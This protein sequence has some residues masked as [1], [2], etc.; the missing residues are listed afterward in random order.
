M[1]LLDMTKLRGIAANAA[2]TT[3][4]LRGA[5]ERQQGGTCRFGD[6]LFISRP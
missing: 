2:A 5:K 1:R 6:S 4:M 3:R